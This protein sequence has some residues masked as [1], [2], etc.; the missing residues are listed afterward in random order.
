L[1]FFIFSKCKTKKTAAVNEEKKKERK[2]KNE[3]ETGRGK[4]RPPN[5]CV[6]EP[7]VVDWPPMVAAGLWLL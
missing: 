2:K 3:N 4:N 1:P 6:L 7:A 5:I